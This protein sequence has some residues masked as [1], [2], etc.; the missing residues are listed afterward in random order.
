LSRYGADAALDTDRWIFDR[1][2][3]H[4]HRRTRAKL[5]AQPV[6]D[7]SAALEQ[8]PFDSK[9][10]RGRLQKLAEKLLY[11]EASRAIA[12]LGQ[13]S[14]RAERLITRMRKSEEFLQH[15]NVMPKGEIELRESLITRRT[16][17]LSEALETAQENAQ[18]RAPLMAHASHEL[19]SPLNGIIGTTELLLAK[20][21]ADDPTAEGLGVVMNC[22]EDIQRVVADLVTMSE[23]RANRFKL[24]DEP[25]DLSALLEQVCQVIEPAAAVKGVVLRRNNQLTANLGAAAMASGSAR[26]C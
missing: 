25:C 5:V 1:D 18:T 26:F 23:L 17:E 10:F 7:V 2:R 4:R 11:A 22:A 20:L 13:Y 21:Q 3:D 12:T 19:R 14:E 8:L 24:A 6:L 15:T 9:D 16:A